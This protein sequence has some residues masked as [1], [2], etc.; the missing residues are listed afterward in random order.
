MRPAGLQD[1]LQWAYLKVPGSR[2]PVS[3]YQPCTLRLLTLVSLRWA[4][5]AR[6]GAVQVTVQVDSHPG[7]ASETKTSA[8]PQSCDAPNTSS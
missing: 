1:D 2:S 4:G 6:D 8:G 3:P 5:S 7:L